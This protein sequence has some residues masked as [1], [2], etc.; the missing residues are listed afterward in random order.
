MNTV[1]RINNIL[2]DSVELVSKRLDNGD[3]F[4]LRTYDA[5]DEERMVGIWLEHPDRSIGC[6]IMF[7]ITPQE[8]DFL[9]KSLIALAE[10]I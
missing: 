2:V 10:N 8:A 5:T 7:E 1:I 3:Q 6:T 9:G 4:N